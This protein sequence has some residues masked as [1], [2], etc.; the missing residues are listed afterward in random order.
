MER[1]VFFLGGNSVRTFVCKD[2]KQA[3]HLLGYHNYEFSS[4]ET[5]PVMKRV[6]YVVF[7]HMKI[8]ISIMVN[9]FKHGFKENWI[10]QSGL[11]SSDLS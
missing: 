10:D 9:I 6:L 4:C 5:R 8:N 1:M 3:L 11:H 7:A 2:G